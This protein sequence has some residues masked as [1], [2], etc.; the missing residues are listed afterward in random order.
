MKLGLKTNYYA[1]NPQYLVHGH[2]SCANAHCVR[3]SANFCA[4][5]LADAT[6]EAA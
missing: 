5:V 6:V 4:A 3:E 1:C 2:S